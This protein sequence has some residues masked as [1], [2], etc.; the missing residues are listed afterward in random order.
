MSDSPRHISKKAVALRYDLSRDSAPKVVAK[1]ERL[2]AEAIIALAREHG[3][4]IQEDPDLVAV[5]GKLDLNTEIPEALYRAVAEVLA[6]V[7]R[8][9]QSFSG[10]EESLPRVKS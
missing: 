4:H 1:G 10:P 5:L 3:V 2:R 8:L 7:Y 9:N 6:F